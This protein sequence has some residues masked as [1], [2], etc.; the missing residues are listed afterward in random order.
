M[1]RREPLQ[2]VPNRQQA[3]PALKAFFRS[4]GLA[5]D[6][7]KIANVV[8]TLFRANIQ[9]KARDDLEQ[10]GAKGRYG[11]ISWSGA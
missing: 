8:G 3:F 11:L 2:G 4:L 5:G 10:V 1:A 7:R 9:A 6:L